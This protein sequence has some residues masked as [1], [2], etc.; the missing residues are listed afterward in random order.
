MFINT[1]SIIPVIC[2][3]YLQNSNKILNDINYSSGMSRYY[4]NCLTPDALGCST[5][6]QYR[7]KLYQIEKVQRLYELIY[8]I[9]NQ[10]NTRGGIRL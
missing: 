8:K 1:S 3:N 6:N 5:I 9:K 2:H 10:S 7:F 4:Q